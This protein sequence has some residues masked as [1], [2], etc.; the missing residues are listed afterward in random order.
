M[1]FRGSCRF[2]Q[3]PD[4]VDGKRVSSRNSLQQPKIQTRDLDLVL[5]VDDERTVTFEVSMYAIEQFAAA[6]VD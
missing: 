2:A 3:D 1:C 5:S 6:S 4:C